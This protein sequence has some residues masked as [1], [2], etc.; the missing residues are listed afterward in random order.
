MIS[1][2]TQRSR[3]HF[4]YNILEKL[5]ITNNLTVSIRRL[6]SIVNKYQFDL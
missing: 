5:L 3:Y 4:N 6:I 2:G 1:G